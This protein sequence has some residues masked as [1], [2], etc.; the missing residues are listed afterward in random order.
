MKP[1]TEKA[2]SGKCGEDCAVRYLKRR[3]YKII[4]RNYRIRHKELDII[5]ENKEYIVFVEVKT[6][7]GKRSD[8]GSF[9]SPAHAVD[10][11]K[12]ENTISCA[13]SYLSSHP[14]Q[15]QPRIDVIEIW[16]GGMFPKVNHIKNAVM[17][18]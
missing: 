13:R 6:H 8:D 12:R 4:S 1:K 10:R 18:K 11:K 7:S 2:R 15:K 17:A 16:L 5:A 9:G 3:G 14:C